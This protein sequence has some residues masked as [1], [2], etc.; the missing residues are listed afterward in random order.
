MKKE[1]K[2]TALRVRTEEVTD[3]DVTAAELKKMIQH[4]R[5]SE[6]QQVVKPVQQE[7]NFFSEMDYCTDSGHPQT[8]KMRW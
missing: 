7:W 5:K 4:L 2:I 6:K 1:K 8:E 3:L